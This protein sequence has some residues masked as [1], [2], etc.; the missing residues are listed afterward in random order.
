MMLF[1]MT[2]GHILLNCNTDDMSA[3]FCRVSVIMLDESGKLQYK[4]GILVY[5]VISKFQGVYV[6]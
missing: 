5:E 1:Q 6:S 3:T 2:Y 4:N